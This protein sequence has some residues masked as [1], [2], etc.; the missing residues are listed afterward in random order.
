MQVTYKE[1]QS[2]EKYQYCTNSNGTDKV[3]YC[4]ILVLENDD[5][6]CEEII[7]AI[8]LSSTSSASKCFCKTNPDA[9][10]Q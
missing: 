10:I 9:T 1:I 6:W 4:S 8:M 7:F 3:G 2:I 5:W